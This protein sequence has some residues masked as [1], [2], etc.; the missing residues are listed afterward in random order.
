MEQHLSAPQISLKSVLPR[1]Y[2]NKVRETLHSWD[3]G[4]TSEKA[5]LE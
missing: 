2:E 4:E 1:I 5:F 3:M